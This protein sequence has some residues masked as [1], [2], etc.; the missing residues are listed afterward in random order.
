MIERPDPPHPT[1]LPF[2]EREQTERAE[3]TVNKIERCCDKHFHQPQR[4]HRTMPAT[5]ST[6]TCEPSGMWRVA[7]ST[8][9]TIGMP[10]P[11]AGEARRE[12]EPP[13]PGTTPPPRGPE[14]RRAGPAPWATRL[15]P[16]ATRGSSHPQFTPTARPEL[17]PIPAG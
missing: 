2:G 4:S 14:G 6:A 8:P 1:P 5:P 7:S 15:S 11:R 13:N 3:V 10:R 17:Q 16:G 12:G 9:S